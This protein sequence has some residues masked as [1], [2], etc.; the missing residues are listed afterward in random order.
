MASGWSGPGERV[1][2]D[3]IVQVAG[4]GAA[5]KT[6]AACYRSGHINETACAKLRRVVILLSPAYGS[7]ALSHPWRSP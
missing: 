2:P 4:E 1:P 3:Q 5:G 6:A 7:T